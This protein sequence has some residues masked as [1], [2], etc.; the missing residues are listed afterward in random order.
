MLLCILKPTSKKI[1]NCAKSFVLKEDLWIVFVCLAHRFLFIA[2]KI[3][4]FISQT[5]KSEN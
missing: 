3:I 1:Y 2:L 5:I 4:Y